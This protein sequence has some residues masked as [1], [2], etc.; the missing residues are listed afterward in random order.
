MLNQFSYHEE[1]I[2]LSV[3]LWALSWEL[4]TAA[5]GLWL[6]ARPHLASWHGEPSRFW[7]EHGWTR[8]GPEVTLPGEPSAAARVA[9]V[10]LEL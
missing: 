2:L 3:E 6:R 5:A 7:P 9:P 4:G 8:S 10:T 1:A